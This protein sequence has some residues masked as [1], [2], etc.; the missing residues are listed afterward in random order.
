[1]AADI[2][3]ATEIYKTGGAQAIAALSFGTKSIS[4]VDKIV[5][6]GGPFVTAGKSLV[7]DQTSIDMKAGPTE[8]GIIADESADPEFIAADLISQAEHSNDTFCYLLTTSNSLAKK[9]RNH[10]LR[11]NKKF[12]KKQYCKK[13]PRVKWLSLQF[14]HQK[15]KL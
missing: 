11:K 9:V 13:K 12:Q 6:P 15:I 5:G 10:S 1:M 7:S 14:V 2:C 3:G 4:K 8:L